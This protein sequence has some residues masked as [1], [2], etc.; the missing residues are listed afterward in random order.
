MSVARNETADA[1]R[2]I[3]TLERIGSVCRRSMIPLTAD[4]GFEYL[5]SLRFD[6]NHLLFSYIFKE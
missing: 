1:V 2:S 5:V 6:Q 4:S 3:R